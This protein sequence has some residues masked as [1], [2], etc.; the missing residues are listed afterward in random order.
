MQRID[1]SRRFRPGIVLVALLA[2]GDSAHAAD[3]MPV[4]LAT[5][6]D[7][8]R[9]Q[10]DA[11]F[12]RFRQ[13]GSPGAALAIYHRGGIAYSRS[14]GLADLEHGVAIA[15]STVFNIGS[16]SKQFTAFSIALLAREGKVDLHTDI[17]QYLPHLADFGKP[18]TVDNLLH[19]TSGVRDY[20]A[21]A[22][23]RGGSDSSLITQA[24]AVHLL[25]QQR[26]LNFE[27]GTQYA[28]SNAGYVL[29]AQ[30]V[31]AVSG[32]T[33]AQYEA[34][35]IFEPL[36]MTHTRVRE[37]LTDVVPDYA[38]GYEEGKGSA[39]W[40]HAVYNREVVGPGNVL[41]NATDLTRWAANFLH[42]KVGDSALI[43]QVSA[44]GSFADGAQLNYG[45]G[46]TH[47]AFAGH[48]AIW[49]TGRVP[50]FAARLAVFPQEEFAVVITAN[51]YVAP[52]EPIERITA[53]YL[54]ETR[55]ANPDPATV[56]L[57]VAELATLAGYYQTDRGQMLQLLA[58][59]H[60]LQAR[61]PSGETQPVTCWADGTFGLEDYNDHRMRPVRST[62]GA[63]T[64]LEVIGAE[65]GSRVAERYERVVPA[66]PSATE[67]Q[68]IAGSY[69]SP[70]ID[71][72]YTLAAQ[73]GKLVLRSLGLV[74]PQVLVPG[75]TGRFDSVSGPLPDLSLTVEGGTH[76]TVRTLILHIQDVYNLSMHRT[77]RSVGE[78]IP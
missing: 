8:T 9:A 45:F 50:G 36:G 37:K 72:T 58:A 29:L 26:G 43:A 75:A 5:T 78:K 51:T 48:E 31:Q 32:Q 49:H 60:A 64:A 61:W 30:I 59:G 12:A 18:I 62:T 15:P 13:T 38:V 40:L 66:Q 35:H 57:G 77:D 28:Y 39:P 7:T 34:R 73:S 41:S 17:R 11:V 69:Y 21:L 4:P 27:P 52:D 42:P 55:G 63:V 54:G 25:E 68:Q 14:Y 3:P 6:P 24:E 56:H 74:E 33:L 76:G 70:E 47:Q 44:R 71:A 10:V 53:L 1:W 23:L 2:L 67:L 19:H 20:V 22:R 46:V 16:L 65:G